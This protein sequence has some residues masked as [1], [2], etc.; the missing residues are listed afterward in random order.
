MMV[1]EAE[2]NLR[3]SCSEISHSGVKIN[4]VINKSETIVPN[5]ADPQLVAYMLQEAMEDQPCSVC[6]KGGHEDRQ[7]ICDRCNL[8]YHTFCI[9]MT[10]IPD[11]YWYCPRCS[12]AIKRQGIKDETED[13]AF[14][15]TI[16]EKSDAGVQGENFVWSQGKL[17]IFRGIGYLE[18]PPLGSRKLVMEESHHSLMH[19][20][21]DKLCARIGQE[22]WWPNMLEDCKRY[23]R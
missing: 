6:K 5:K 20:G 21:A 8:A 2:E 12:N 13:I 10:Y 16:K 14:L 3:G 18:Y 19:I 17:H 4:H 23:V 1:A 11:V 15:R 7:L 9:K 22:Y